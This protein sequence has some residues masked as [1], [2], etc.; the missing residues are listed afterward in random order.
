MKIFL[1]FSFSFYFCYICHIHAATMNNITDV[2][3]KIK[4]NTTTWSSKSTSSIFPKKTKILSP[5]CPT[6]IVALFTIAKSWKQVLK[7]PSTDEWIKMWCY[8]CV[9]YTYKYTHTH[10]HT[11]MC[12]VAQLC[13][14]DPMDCS[15]P[16]SSVNGDSPS[17]RL[18]RGSSQPR[19]WT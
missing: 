15:L 14:C 17:S 12:L 13:L 6:F 1:F 16:G 18:S 19:D 8:V 9:T 10:T 11:R 7:Y 5:K 4:N 3:E 2:S